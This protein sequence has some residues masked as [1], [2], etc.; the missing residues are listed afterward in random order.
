MS[1]TGKR[2]RLQEEFHFPIFGCTALFLFVLLMI[3]Y[4]GENCKSSHTVY[5]A[6]RT[7]NRHLM[8]GEAERK[9]VERPKKRNPTRE[10]VDTVSKAQY[11]NDTMSE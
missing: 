11:N 7:D 9:K 4:K 10:G 6:F 2:Q 3:A 1:D 8:N 5:A